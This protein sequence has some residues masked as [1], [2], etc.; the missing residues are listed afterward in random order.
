MSRNHR[1]VRATK[2]HRPAGCGS[3]LSPHHRGVRSTAS[4]ATAPEFTPSVP[5]SSG[6]PLNRNEEYLKAQFEKSLL[7][8]HYR[9]VRSTLPGGQLQRGEPSVP[10]SSGSPLNSRM[11]GLGTTQ[12]LLSPHHRGVRS[13]MRKQLK[14]SPAKSPQPSVPSSSGSPLNRVR[15]GSRPDFFP[16]VPSS[17]GSPLNGGLG[18]Q[19]DREH[20]CPLIIGESAQPCVT[21]GET[22]ARSSF[23]PLIIG[24]SA[25]RAPRFGSHS[26]GLLSPHHRGVRSTADSTESMY[27]DPSVPSS[28]GS[29]L[30]STPQKPRRYAGFQG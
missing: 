7:S 14:K 29:P 8:P 18:P 3:L 11:Y 16:S 2:L 26:V 21:S 4:E 23:C 15:G 28:S 30:N 5:S 13:T 17:S 20:F 24:E 1:G 9:G 25:Q 10:S 22:P 6:S 12:S 27:V 19:D